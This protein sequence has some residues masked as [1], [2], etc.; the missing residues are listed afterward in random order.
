MSHMFRLDMIMAILSVILGPALLMFYFLDTCKRILR[1]EFGHEF[2][3]SVVNANRLEFP[4]VRKAL[5][6]FNAPVDYE[7]FRMQLKCDFL[8][9]TYLLKNAGNAKG[10]LSKE[11]RFL[12]WYFNAVVL[13]LI[14]THWLR[15]SERAA[16]LRLTSILEYFANV[17]GERVDTI[18]FGDMTASDYLMSL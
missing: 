11:E 12:T 2:F 4:F 18:R 3:H 6:E 17:L 13:K 15:L 1:R 10:R 8:A 14:I 5:E 7:R 9:L 16:V